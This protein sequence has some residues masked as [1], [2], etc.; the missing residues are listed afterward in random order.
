MSRTLPPLLVATLPLAFPLSCL[1]E[2]DIRDGSEPGPDCKAVSAC[3]L[4]TWGQNDELGGASAGGG[5]AG[6]PSGRCEDEANLLKFSVI[7]VPGYEDAADFVF[8]PKG[9]HLLLAE[10]GGSIRELAFERGELREVWRAQLPDEVL[11]EEACGVTNLLLDPEF[12]D[13]GMVYVSYCSSNRITRLSRIT[14]DAGKIEDLQVILETVL[15]ADKDGWHRFGSMGFE[16]DGRT[17]WMFS[18]DQ[19]QR[20]EA[21]DP[22]SLR[23]KLL[24]IQ[25]HRSPGRGGYEPAAGNLIEQD[26]E[27]DP[28]VFA[29]GFRSP[30][31]AARDD[32]GRIFVGDVGDAYAE[33]VNLVE[34]AGQN[35][36][37]SRHEGPCSGDCESFR[38]PLAWYTR[39]TEDPYVFDDPETEPATKR[40][41]WVGEIYR[42]P[43]KG[44]RYCGLLGGVV[45]FGDFFTG[46]VRGLRVDE[47][48]TVLV[49]RLLGH[50]TEITS[51]RQGGDGYLYALTYR[52]SLLRIE[53]DLETP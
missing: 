27:A 5:D 18:G 12:E 34:A 49:D 28:A 47:E 39:S 14:L 9:Q 8:L 46:W 41:V 21:Q 48:G 24:R 33:E 20:V 44:D 50:H 30:W 15:K 1:G 38:D 51:V 16:E 6:G 37:W 23:G 13:N 10:R 3:A 53:L 26:P 35:F 25:P 40:A 29:L 22:K 43:A 17:L 11:N 32:A 7:S 36:G 19:T 31:R 52:G 45:P 4:A 2:A 42:T